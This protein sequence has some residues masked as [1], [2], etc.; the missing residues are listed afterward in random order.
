MKGLN[1][2]SLSFPV[3]CGVLYSPHEPDPEPY[4]PVPPKLIPLD[5]VSTCY[6][7]MEGVIDFNVSFDNSFPF[8]WNVSS[9]FQS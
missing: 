2:L 7:L 3:T 5:E 9:F 4:E 1:N 8:K 6:V